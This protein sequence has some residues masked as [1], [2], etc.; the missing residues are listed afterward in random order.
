MIIRERER[1][2]LK[3]FNLTAI[4]NEQWAMNSLKR[5]FFNKN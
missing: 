3:I 5:V 1:D 4:I 2:F